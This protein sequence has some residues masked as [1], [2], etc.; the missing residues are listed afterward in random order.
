MALRPID[1]F[2][3]LCAPRR[4]FSFDYQKESER[5]RKLGNLVFAIFLQ[6]ESSICQQCQHF[7]GNRLLLLICFLSKNGVASACSA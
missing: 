5:E 3:I 4:L 7:N 1:R 2:C 6:S